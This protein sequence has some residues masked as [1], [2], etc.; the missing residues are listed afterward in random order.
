MP[1]IV[2]IRIRFQVLPTLASIPQPIAPSPT[3]MSM[4]INTPDDELPYGNPRITSLPG[5]L[6]VL[7]WQPS[8]N[9]HFGE[10]I[11]EHGH[12][13]TQI[14]EEVSRNDAKAQRKSLFVAPLRRC[15]LFKTDG[16]IEE[17]SWDA[18]RFK[19]SSSL[20]GSIFSGFLRNWRQRGIFKAELTLD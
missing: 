9:S 6:S 19:P 2:S 17:K 7:S 8:G 20:K 11:R 5:M 13:T 14:G 10:T 1:W 3:F 4:R 18:S 12:P 15:V 16:S